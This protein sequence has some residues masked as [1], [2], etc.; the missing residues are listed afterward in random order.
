M[1]QNEN[2]LHHQEESNAHQHH[3]DVITQYLYNVGEYVW[4]RVPNFEETGTTS[5]YKSIIEVLFV[6]KE[7]L[8]HTNPTVRSFVRDTIKIFSV[9]TAYY[10][11]YKVGGTKYHYDE[12]LLAGAIFKPICKAAFIGL[13]S[14]VFDVLAQSTASRV[15]NYLCETPS[16]AL[17]TISRARQDEYHNNP[18]TANSKTDIEFLIE[19]LTLDLAWESTISAVI[20]TITTDI[21]GKIYG[22]FMKTNIGTEANPQNVHTLENLIDPSGLIS[23]L[24]EKAQKL[25][26]QY[27]K[28][29]V[30]TYFLTPPARAIEDL[31][32][33][34][35]HSTAFQ[36]AR[37][38]F[39]ESSQLLQDWIE[40]YSPTTTELEV[41]G[42]DNAEL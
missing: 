10:Y 17:T 42:K 21:L 18:E 8:D 22:E 14:G 23:V 15:S 11:G 28:S 34:V 29:L 25:I 35:R 12:Y 37:E 40:Y 13:T 24:P 7:L 39:E 16:R 33:L 20:K 1:S 31:P 19:N 36:E 32:H 30:D 4:E 27:L 26:T 5:A 2:T 6:P 41:N 9:A 38:F 3:I